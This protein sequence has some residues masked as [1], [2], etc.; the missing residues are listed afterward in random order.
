MRNSHAK[1]LR[2]GYWASVGLHRGAHVGEEVQHVCR[3]VSNARVSIYGACSHSS[4]CALNISKAVGLT[5]SKP[6]RVK[7]AEMLLSN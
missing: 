7:A 2:C 5:L 1:V 4:A 6:A 3:K